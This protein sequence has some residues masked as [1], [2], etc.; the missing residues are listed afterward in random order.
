MKV[1]T[2]KYIDAEGDMQHGKVLAQIKNLVHPLKEGR[3]GFVPYLT[4]TPQ[5]YKIAKPI[6]VRSGLVRKRR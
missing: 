3:Y 2:L 5:E 6:L 1:T 4:L